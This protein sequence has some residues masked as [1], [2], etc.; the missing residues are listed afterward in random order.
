MAGSISA[1]A[2]TAG[3]VDYL[4]E[5]LSNWDKARQDPDVPGHRVV[6]DLLCGASGG[7][8]TSAMTL[9]ALHD[10]L[11]HAKLGQD[12]RSYV[13]PANNILW[14]SWVELND[15]D[16]FRDI[17][18]PTDLQQGYVPSLINSKFIEQ[19]AMKFE[20]YARELAASG[21]ARPA[22]VSAAMET[23][24]TLFNVTGM[25]Y[26]L[27]TRSST[28]AGAASQFIFEHRDIAHFRL[29]ETY[30][31]DGRIPLSPAMLNYLNVLIEASLATGAFPIGL[32]ARKLTREA[33]FIWD[34]PFF[35]R[36]LFNSATIGLG[37]KN[38]QPTD[39]YTSINADGGVANNEPVELA[40]RIMRTMRAHHYG[41]LKLDKELH[42]LT[43]EDQEDRLKQL[44]NSSVL[45]IDPFPSTNSVVKL[46]GERS[47]NL[48][49]YA[50][51]LVLAMRSQL[52]FDAKEALKGYDKANYGLHVIA[53]SKDGVSAPMALACASV[54]GFGGFL[55][56]E[57]RVHD[58]FLG[59]SNCQ[60]FLRKYFIADLNEQDPEARKCIQSV[61]DAYQEN[62]SAFRRF[63][64]QDEQGKT[65]VPII[66]DVTLKSP[67]EYR[68]TDGKGTYWQEHALPV[69][70]L[71][72]L[73]PDYLDA[74]SSN[75]S[76]RVTSIAVNLIKLGWFGRFVARLLSVVF[77]RQLVKLISAR[78]KA[79]LYKR[80]LMTK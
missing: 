53:P 76:N 45:L 38:M 16:V 39:L 12:G 70:N 44:T 46:P 9:F 34:N 63:A 11:D 51:D 57:F 19:V 61:I 7:G 52:L 32:S 73:A 2:Y 68:I 58:Y 75:F 6:I 67:I 1:G 8:I 3:V 66:P 4:I 30:A 23:I 21:P 24:L 59:R 69:Y 55:N 28:A 27:Y 5:S 40:R 18:T 54:G 31:S 35:H 62:E 49:H 36:G 15:D 22:Y 37:R 29:A 79:D 14:D 47:E 74:Y 72:P 64:F 71:K 43:K 13:K 20:N 10:K 77:R 78:I 50:P 33:R 48:L 41:D 65:W 80:G 17:L 42:D 56:R 60:S 26:R 25:S